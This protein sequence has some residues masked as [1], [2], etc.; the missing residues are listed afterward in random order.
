M[1][2]FAQRRFT[3]PQSALA[4]GVDTPRLASLRNYARRSPRH[5]RGAAHKRVDNSNCDKQAIAHLE[6]RKQV[7]VIE[8]TYAPSDFAVGTINFP[9]GLMSIGRAF[10][11]SA[12]IEEVFYMV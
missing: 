2:P 8:I 9:R 10:K 1:V 4:A 12:A 11:T 5:S 6:G 3:T 7:C